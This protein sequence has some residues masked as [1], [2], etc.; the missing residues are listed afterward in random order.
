MGRGQWRGGGENGRKDKQRVEEAKPGRASMGS[1]K[2][3]GKELL[4]GWVEDIVKRRGE[5][6]PSQGQSS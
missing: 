6:E 2:D 3:S 5:G 1:L 4:Q